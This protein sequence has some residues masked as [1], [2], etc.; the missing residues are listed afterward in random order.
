MS[1]GNALRSEWTKLKSLRSTWV[2]AVLLVGSIAA[3]TMLFSVAADHGMTVSWSMLLVGAVIFNMIAIAFAGSTAAGEYND[4]MHAHA[5]LTQD[6]RS[7]W[8]SARFLLTVILL[9][10]CW[11]LGIAIAYAAVAVSPVVSFEGGQ[12]YYIFTSLLG[13]VVF[14]LISMSLG[15][16]TKSRVAA[17]AIPLV[18]LLVVENMLGYAA[19]A[20]SALRPIWLVAPGERIQ[21][22]APQLSGIMTNPER[23]HIGFEAG[24][25]QPLWFNVLVVV[26]WIVLAIAAAQWANAKRDVK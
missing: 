8:L 4:Q 15:V 2:Y 7:L 25:T 23:P 10:A 11:V 20:F 17:V 6:R 18:W 1:F 22:L 21:Q 3:P 5:F 19:S 24:M 12:T 26:A 16:L 14:S 9:A 13:F